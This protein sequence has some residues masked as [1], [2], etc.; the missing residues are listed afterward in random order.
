MALSVEIGAGKDLPPPQGLAALEQVAD[1][2]SSSACTLR[3]RSPAPQLY[4]FPVSPAPPC[5][6]VF[7]FLAPLEQMAD[8]DSSFARALLASL[9]GPALAPGAAT[10]SAGPRGGAGGGAGWGT[11]NAGEEVLNALRSAFKQ[12]PRNPLMAACLQVGS[13][14]IQIC[15]A[16]EAGGEGGSGVGGDDGSGEKW[17]G[18]GREDFSLSPSINSPKL[19]DLCCMLPCT[20]SVVPPPLSPVPPAPSTPPSCPLPTQS[21][22]RVQVHKQR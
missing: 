7:S 9:S 14:G 5:P 22:A 8:R 13:K 10:P 20:F 19:Y 1:R 21:L 6:Q 4:P 15:E 16:G 3:A 11:G 12:R 17:F 18:G 2:D